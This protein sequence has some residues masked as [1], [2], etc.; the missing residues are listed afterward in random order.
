ME[1]VVNPSPLLIHSAL[2]D[3]T[4]DRYTRREFFPLASPDYK[5]TADVFGADMMPVCDQDLNTQLQV[6]G[7]L[8][9]ERYEEKTVIRQPN[10]LSHRV[11]SM[12]QAEHEGDV[13]FTPRYNIWKH[14]VDSVNC[15]IMFIE[16][17]S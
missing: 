2:I 15:E 5:L 12:L 7:M 13:R 3:H 10:S 4:M 1:V 11:A 17:T 14:P 9:N 8:S 16:A 6:L